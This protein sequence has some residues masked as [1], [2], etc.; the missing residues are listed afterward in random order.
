MANFVRVAAVTDIPAGQG[1]AV[2]VAGTQMAIFNCG[3]RLLCDRHRL[4]AQGRP[5][6]RG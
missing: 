1:K 3:R 5:A 2:E 6:R 4:Q